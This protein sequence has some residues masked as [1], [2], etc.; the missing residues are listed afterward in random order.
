MGKALMTLFAM[1]AGILAGVVT[2]FSLVAGKLG[3]PFRR[4]KQLHRKKQM[5]VQ[6]AVFI[7]TGQVLMNILF[8]VTPLWTLT[9][10]E[11]NMLVFSSVT[12]VAAVYFAL[13]GYWRY[14]AWTD[15][16]KDEIYER[17]GVPF[18]KNLVEFGKKLD[19]RWGELTPGQRANILSRIDT[20]AEKVFER[21]S[22]TGKP[23]P[24]LKE[25]KKMEVDE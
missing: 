23:K 15:A 25:V 14:Y 4:Y 13:Y 1:L 11:W 10:V 2:M 16:A 12:S 7:I 5:V 8:V 20:V 22:D 9:W 21:L 19:K 18:I 17:L 3:A 24:K 6:A